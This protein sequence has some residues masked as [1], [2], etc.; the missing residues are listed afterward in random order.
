MRRRSDIL[1]F[2]G[3]F[4]TPRTGTAVLLTLAVAVSAPACA[5]ILGFEDTTLRTEDGGALTEG[6]VDPTEGGATDGGV[7]KLGATPAALLLRR[8]T[9]ASIAI[10]LVRSDALRGVVTIRAADLPAGVTATDAV[11]AEGATTA[12]ITL[13]ASGTSV[14]GAATVKLA[15]QNPALADAT[16]ALVVADQ[17]GALDL[18]FDVDGRVTDNSKGA[19]A[20]F[21]ALALQG[22]GKIVAGGGAATGWLARRFSSAGAPEA[23]FTAAATGLPGNGDLRAMAIDTT[24]RIVCVGTSSALSGVLKQQLT[25]LRLTAAGAIDTTFGSGVVRLTDA[26]APNGSEG[27]GVTIQ[28]DGKII[29]VGSRHEAAADENGIA[30]RLTT[31]GARDTTFNTT[32]SLTLTDT[33]L[34]GV[35]VEPAGE[36]TL[37]GSTIAAALPSYVF[38]RRTALGAVDPTFG[39]AGVAAFGNTYGA[40]AF[41]RLSSGALAIVG[42]ARQGVAAYTAG[43]AATSGTPVFARALAT[44][45]G[46][47]LYGVAAQADNAIVAAG[48]TAGPDGEARV[49]RVLPNGAKDT[50]FGNGGTAVIEAPAVPNNIEVELFAVAVQADGRILAAG[51]RSDTGAAIYRLWQ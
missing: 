42:N 23:P 25:V 8:G 7:A 15:A 34:I 29:V 1:R 49:E 40:N 26:E 36:I 19:A 24:G 16:L 17:A 14:L 20:A 32:G 27:L 22:D 3:S 46:A 13:T 39:T 10:S 6:G 38:N 50:T 51:N 41:V 31:A 30:L 4:P 43:V 21:F 45:A 11:I 33:R 9:T 44:A 35:A 37:A 12:V 5:S 47:G 48:H 28:T 18:T 2:L